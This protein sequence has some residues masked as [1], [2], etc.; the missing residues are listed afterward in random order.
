MAKAAWII[1]DM[2]NETDPRLRWDKCYLHG[3]EQTINMFH[4]TETP[5]FP[6]D[7]KVHVDLN[8]WS[9]KTPIRTN[10]FVNDGLSIKLG[11]L[12]HIRKVITTME[13][14][15]EAVTRLKHCSTLLSNST[16]H[17]NVPTTPK[18]GI[19]QEL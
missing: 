8:M 17:V 2:A 11:N 1:N 7:L 13:W 19:H 5:P 18:K 15:H 9:F 14:K 6:T 16:P 4:K 10:D 3:T 12:V